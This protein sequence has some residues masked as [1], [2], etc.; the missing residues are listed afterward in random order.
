[1]PALNPYA[2]RTMQYETEPT[3]Y[4]TLLQNNQAAS[5][6]GFT[7][8]VHINRAFCLLYYFNCLWYLFQLRYFE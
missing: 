3:K 2:L 1:M 7:V 6:I 5:A 4:A 8:L